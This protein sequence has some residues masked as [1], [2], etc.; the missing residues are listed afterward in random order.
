MNRTLQTITQGA[1][2]AGTLLLALAS[3]PAQAQQVTIS[4]FPPVTFRATTQPVY[5][6]G[7]AAYYYSGRWYYQRGG[8][9]EY[10]REE[11]RHLR[12][13]RSNRHPPRPHYEKRHRGRGR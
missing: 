5:Y 6:E 2:V 8:E 11:P 7:H 10:Y 13:Y 3:A 12:E 1:L 9:W 4:L